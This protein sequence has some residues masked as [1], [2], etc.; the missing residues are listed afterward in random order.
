[1]AADIV[2]IGS[3]ELIPLISQY[4]KSIIYQPYAVDLTILDDIAPRPAACF[5]IGYAGTIHHQHDFKFLNQSIQRI[6]K[7]IPQIHWDFIGC[8]PEGAAEMPNH[9]FTPFIPNYTNFL[10]NL[11]WRNW[12]I[13]LCPIMDLPHNRCKTDN[14]LREYGACRIAGIYSNIPPY[15]TNVQSGET[16][17]LV[18]NNEQ[19]WYDAIKTLIDNDDLRNKIAVQTRRWVEEQR[20]IPTV[21]KLW[22]ELFQQVLKK[23]K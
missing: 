20:S 4:N 8:L 7:E 14:K 22:V 23:R 17:L 12:Q 18:E 3:P 13:G 9:T 1:R 5:T 6:M 16:G 11:Y 19:A 10:Q 21:A 2:K 15:S